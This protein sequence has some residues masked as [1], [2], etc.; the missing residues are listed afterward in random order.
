MPSISKITVRPLEVRDFSFVRELAAS[1]PNFTIPP[2]Y[3]LWL[4]TRISPELCLVAERPDKGPL[5][6]LLAVPISNPPKSL[7]IWQLAAAKVSDPE[8]AMMKLIASLRDV[9]KVERVKKLIFS[10]QP[11]TATFRILKRYS[12]RGFSTDP[13]DIGCLP[14]IVAPDEH[15]FCVTIPPGLKNTQ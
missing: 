11:K 7:Y 9:V 8:E 4:L 1:Q 12:R 10:A 3:V 13:Q 2:P 5:G 15:E 6:Y 14:E